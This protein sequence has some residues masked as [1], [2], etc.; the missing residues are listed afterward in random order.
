MI[1]RKFIVL[2]YLIITSNCS[3]LNQTLDINK[4][5]PHDIEI[6]VNNIK[7]KGIVIAPFSKKYEIRIKAP[8][9]L[10]LLQWVTCHRSKYQE[11]AGSWFSGSAAYFEYEPQYKEEHDRCDMQ[12]YGYE[13]VKGRHASAYVLFE[14]AKYKVQARLHCNGSTKYLNGVGGCSSKAGTYQQIEFGSEVKSV[15]PMADNCPKL[16]DADK[17]Q[18]KLPRGNCTYIFKEGAKFF[19]L[20]T[21]GWDEPLIRGG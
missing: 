16:P 4:Y 14:S 17:I 1:F 10:D 20:K 12:I 21:Y 18:F 19:R 11:K 5:Y 3:N 8:G 2:I 13:K 9:K 15:K 6:K 7:G